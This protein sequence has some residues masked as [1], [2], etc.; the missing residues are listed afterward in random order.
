MVCLPDVRKQLKL[1]LQMTAI[2]ESGTKAGRKFNNN[3]IR[4]NS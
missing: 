4:E 2:M 3:I 1:F